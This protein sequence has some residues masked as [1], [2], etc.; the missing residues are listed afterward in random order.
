M[1][2]GESTGPA[3]PEIAG[4]AVVEPADGGLRAALDRAF[5]EPPRPPYRRTKAVIVV[6]D[7]RVVAE[8]YA[9]GYGIETR[10]LGYSSAKS[11]INALIGILVRQGRLS[12]DQPAVVEEWSDPADPRH[13]ITIDHLLRMTS[14]LAISETRSP[15][16]G[17]ARMIFLE[18]DMAGFAMKSGVQTTPGTS[19]KYTS[20]NTLVL[21]RIVR[22]SA[23]GRAI[24]VLR[25]AHR[26]LFQPLGMRD[27]TIEFDATGTP[28]GSTYIFASARDWA[29]FGL[30]YLNDGIVAGR[31]IFPEGWVQYSS[32][33]TLDTGYGAGF[34]TNKIQGEIPGW[35][36][37]W[38][39]P[40]APQDAIS[41]RGSLGQ[42]VIVMP[43]QRLVIARFGL[44]FAREDAE[45]VG[46][47]VA[48]VIAALATS[49]RRGFG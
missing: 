43:S 32:T 34:W 1:T 33:P 9:P 2:D 3:L 25:F 35:N 41:A 16:C 37:P 30:L 29:R 40:G 15:L 14:G 6:L 42:F 48:D 11:V 47:L 27:V 7:G 21:S 5:A 49:P 24:D 38:A 17:V 8:R 45:G 46:R 18:R 13:A 19:W 12:V 23:G 36:H 22:D 26:E 44:S 4:S 10:L 39:I 20:G 31:R 28:V